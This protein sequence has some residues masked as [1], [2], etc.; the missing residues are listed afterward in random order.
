MWGG[1]P[2][3]TLFYSKKLFDK[4]NDKVVSVEKQ[5]LESISGRNSLWYKKKNLQEEDNSHGFTDE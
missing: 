5:K 2:N 3:K 1:K 4:I